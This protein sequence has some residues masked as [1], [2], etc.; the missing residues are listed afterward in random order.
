MQELSEKLQELQD[1]GFIWHVTHLGAQFVWSR[2]RDGCFLRVCK[3]CHDDDISRTRIRTRYG[4]RVTTKEDH[5]NHL[6]LMLDLLR[7]EKL[8]AKFSKCEFLLQEN[9]IENFSKIAKPLTSLTQNNKKYEWGEKQ[10]EAF[11]MLKDN[12]CNAPILSLQDGV[13]DFVVYCDASNQGL[14][15]VYAKG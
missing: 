7:K 8:Y 12:L 15:L 3:E 11:Q 2:R 13:E 1:K 4:F 5:E 10:K 6:R 14:G 9:F